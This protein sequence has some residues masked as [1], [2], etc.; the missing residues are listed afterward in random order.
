M[1]WEEKL[2]PYHPVQYHVLEVEEQQGIHILGP[3]PELVECG[4]NVV[5][6]PEN[7]GAGQLV[8]EEFA[9]NPES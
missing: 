4:H 1:E 7:V 6:G 5:I 9:E 2:V 8:L 3:I